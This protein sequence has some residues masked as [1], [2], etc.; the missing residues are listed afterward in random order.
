MFFLFLAESHSVIFTVLNISPPDFPPLIHFLFC[1][2]SVK[3]KVKIL[4]RNY[5]ILKLTIRGLYYLELTQELLNLLS[6]DYFIIGTL[7]H[8]RIEFK[9]DF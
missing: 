8:A 2:L 9:Y 5:D 1:F 4:A 7:T 6:N 3:V